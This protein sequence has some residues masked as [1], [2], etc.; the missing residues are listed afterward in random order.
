MLLRTRRLPEP[1]LVSRKRKRCTEESP[2]LPDELWMM[3]FDSVEDI[4]DLFTL[5]K[6]NTQLRRLVLDLSQWKDRILSPEE[7][8][9]LATLAQDDAPYL[10]SLH[11]RLQLT[12][13]MDNM[14]PV[15]PYVEELIVDYEDRGTLEHNMGQFDFPCLQR[16]IVMKP[17]MGSAFGVTINRQMRDNMRR[18]EKLF[19]HHTMPRSTQNHL[20]YL[21]VYSASLKHLIW[22][23]SLPNVKHLGRN[24]EQI[25]MSEMH[26]VFLRDM[27]HVKTFRV[28]G[29]TERWMPA[30]S[31][32]R[33]FGNRGVCDIARVAHQATSLEFTFEG[34]PDVLTPFMVGRTH[35]RQLSLTYHGTAPYIVSMHEIAVFSMVT[36]TLQLMNMVFPEP[37][38][39]KSLFELPHCIANGFLQVCTDNPT[40]I[41]EAM[42]YLQQH[43]RV[44]T[45]E[46]WENN[47]YHLQWSGPVT[48]DLDFWQMDTLAGRPMIVF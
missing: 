18:I 47:T 6:V 48:E 19:V 8:K 13:K 39:W 22:L 26:P 3:I 25:E 37:H 21:L 17:F 15:A 33:P 30:E 29:L 20:L 4:S 10:R 2:P 41:D 32:P 46:T 36:E 45:V 44:G 5:G 42:A 27:D 43:G 28:T 35:L 14:K 9:K 16:L 12:K 11:L 31:E 38:I 24:L 1:V 40:D 34:D 23:G 7:F